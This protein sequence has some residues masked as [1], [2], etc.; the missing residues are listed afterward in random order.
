MKAV[1]GGLHHQTQIVLARIFDLR[2]PVVKGRISVN[3]CIRVRGKRII[4]PCTGRGGLPADGAVT[5]VL[6]TGIRPREYKEVED[7]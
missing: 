1:N 4:R 7:W 5:A 3:L 6:L 2:L